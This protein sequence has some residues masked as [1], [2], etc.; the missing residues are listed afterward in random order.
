M[1]SFKGQSLMEYA[2]PL[3][4]VVIV[5]AV[6]SIAFNDIL[7]SLFTQT[8]NSD[9]TGGPVKAK[10]LATL[11]NPF[12]VLKNFNKAEL[13][14]LVAAMTVQCVSGANACVPTYGGTME[15]SGGMGQ[16]KIDQMTQ[17]LLSALRAAS[18]DSSIDD[19]LQAK[20]RSLAD[21]GL[22]LS[23]IQ[24]KLAAAIADGDV[25]TATLFI[26]AI[27]GGSKTY[28]GTTCLNGATCVIDPDNAALIYS[29]LPATS[30]GSLMDQMRTLE[31]LIE[32]DPQFIA[33][34]GAKDTMIAVFD[35]LN[36]RTGSI[37]ILMGGLPPLTASYTTSEID[38]FVTE[39]TST[40]SYLTGLIGTMNMSTLSDTATDSYV[41]TVQSHSTFSGDD[42][43]TVESAIDSLITQLATA[44]VNDPA[45]QVNLSK[46]TYD[47][48]NIANTT[49]AN[50]DIAQSIAVASDTIYTTAKAN[51]T[52]A[53]SIL[54][55][56]TLALSTAQANLLADPLNPV[57]ISA[58]ATAQA[59]FDASTIFY[60]TAQ[61]DTSSAQAI[62]TADATTYSS[63]QATANTAVTEL[64]DFNTLTQDAFATKL[65][66]MSGDSFSVASKLQSELLADT[67]LGQELI[68]A[69]VAQALS[70]NS[71]NELLTA[72]AGATV[73][74]DAELIDAVMG[75]LSEN[76][77]VTTDLKN[78]ILAGTITTSDTASA[79]D[80]IIDEITTIENTTDAVDALEAMSEGSKKG[81]DLSCDTGKGK[82]YKEHCKK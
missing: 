48:E 23:N 32:S 53:F 67:S 6:A 31:S 20:F 29:I 18:T 45:Y 66:L 55:T 64:S 82:W 74:G 75:V 58:E 60:A 54:N 24:L 73:S 5:V 79:S 12:A 46:G 35:A 14:A 4:M 65:G 70:D 1:R 56:D 68:D 59:N 63:L 57:L 33:I 42:S 3:G 77:T 30:S 71:Y 13:D 38:T 62:A 39:V 81:S 10:K 28:I 72:V 26:N 9:N 52:T 50:A 49:Q 22:E 76:P 80:F 19:A 15:T 11:A 27:N 16:E 2:L 34:P 37:S 41:S 51:E 61:S 78:L 43:D 8:V 40:S 25:A 17:Y 36:V 21:L 47:L 7:V 69:A 44:M